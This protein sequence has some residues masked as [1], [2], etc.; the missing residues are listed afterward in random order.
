MIS[1]IR[2]MCCCKT[3]QVIQPE[4]QAC[5]TSMIVIIERIEAGKSQNFKEDFSSIRQIA[6]QVQ[7][8][9]QSGQD[10]SKVSQS[11]EEVVCRAN[12]LERSMKETTPIANPQTYTLR[13]P[14]SIPSS[15]IEDQITPVYT[16]S[17]KNKLK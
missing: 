11:V 2:W 3:D 5:L 16:A 6:Q 15:N 1:C 12:I 17:S 8:L 13:M 10:L 14:I 7:T 9:S 4:G